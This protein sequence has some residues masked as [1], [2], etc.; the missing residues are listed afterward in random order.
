ME[1]GIQR[2]R[3]LAFAV[4]A[5]PF[6]L[7]VWRFDFLCDDA[8]I[9]FRYARNLAEGHGL[10]FNRGVE[11]PVEGYSEFLWAIV[12]AGG[13]KLGLSPLVLS[14]V[15]SVTAGL[16]LVAVTTRLLVDRVA[17]TRHAARGAA[18]FLG[19]LPP[20]AVWSTGGMATMP[21]AASLVVLFAL[22]WHGER[23]AAPWKLGVAAS[24][25]VLLR[26]DGAYWVAWILGTG[27]VSGWLAR[28]RAR[29]RPALLGAIFSLVVFAA[30][31]T[32]RVTTYGDWL[33]NTARAK[34]GLS[35]AALER[36]S[37]YVAHVLLTF[38]GLILALALALLARHRGDSRLIPLWIVTAASLGYT[39]V[40]GGDFMAFGRFVVP[41]LPFVVLLLG[42]GLSGMERRFGT[43]GA[44][45]ATLLCIVTVL[46]PAFSGALT[47]TS[48]RSAFSVRRN[49]PGAAERGEYEQ[50]WRMRYQMNE[51]RDLG[52]GLALV[53]EP[54]DSLTSA[55]VGAVGYYS[56]LF[57]Y[58]RCGLVTREVTQLP[59]PAVLG[60]PG[61]DKMV[62][63]TF[64]AKDEPTYLDAFWYPGTAEEL[65]RDPRVG[66]GTRALEV[67]PID[68]A[69]SP[70]PEQLLVVER[71]TR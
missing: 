28:E 45:A 15:L 67:L 58:D 64:F 36:G 61:H 53:S 9:T 49:H 8:F 3:W 65:R 6:L 50:W 30:H 7:L 17:P 48:W 1:V 32:W 27:I 51:W 29:W 52:R 38:P 35:G 14:R 20:L 66:G 42:A 11:P 56:R 70:R 63:Y 5:L 40:V 10:I 46:P 41:A 25:V 26:A 21:F 47:P 33:P 57:L 13:V 12:M 22:L 16:V 18:L 31:L 23:P 43:V 37:D 44:L 19:C 24:L 2:R 55:A 54:D 39:V 60:S 62:S 69:K 4:G 59:G 68:P 34:V 71:G